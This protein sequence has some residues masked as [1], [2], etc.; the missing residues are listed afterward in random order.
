[1]TIFLSAIAIDQPAIYE[2]K[3][4]GRLESDLA[5]WFDGEYT[6]QFQP[7]MNE[8]GEKISLTVLTGHV[9]DQSALHGLLAHIRDIGMTLLYVDCLS[10]H[11]GPAQA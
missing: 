2:I 6:Q 8:E 5:D 9:L 3:V 11:E 7:F 1:M 10:A 4:Q